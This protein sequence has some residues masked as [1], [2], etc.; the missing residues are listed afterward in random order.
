MINFSENR[1]TNYFKHFNIQFIFPYLFIISLVFFSRFL[2]INDFG[3]YEDD[4]AFSGTAI[5]NN[6]TQNWIR[7][8][9]SFGSFWQGRPLHMTFLTFIPFIGAKLGG[10][11]ALYL[12]GF[13][14]L[15]LNACLWYS[16]LKKITKNKN[17]AIIASLLFVLYPADTTFGLLQ[18]LIGIQTALLFLLIAFHVYVSSSEKH[19]LNYFR[20]PISYVFATLSLLDYE[21]LFLIFLTAPLLNHPKSTKKEKLYHFLTL[22]IILA[23]YLFLRKLAGESR[24]S[25]ITGLQLIQKVVYQVFWGPLIAFY[26]FFK[27]PIEVISSPRVENIII[28]CIGLILFFI[29]L[30]YLFNKQFLQNDIP[31]DLNTFQEFWKLSGTGLLMTILGYSS[32]LLLSVHDINGRA[33]RVHFSAALGITLILACIWGIAFYITR[34][35]KFWHTLL[36]LLLSVYLSFLLTFS[37]SVQQYYKMSWQY[38]QAFWH[39]VFTLVPDIKEGT[40]ILVQAPSLVWGKQINPFDWSLPVVLESIYDFPDDWQFSPRTYRLNSDVVEPE[41]W[42]DKVISNRKFVLSGKNDGLFFYFPWEPERI[43]EP[44]D[45]V[46]LVEEQGQLVRK[47]KFQTTAGEIIY[48]KPKTNDQP[49]LDLPTT[50]IFEHLMPPPDC[51]YCGSVPRIYFQPQE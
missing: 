6:L 29:V 39:D 18:H 31:A 26:S 40:I 25:G 13:T 4:W 3:L 49:T 7:L 42:K 47:E 14:I 48:L 43:V 17:V 1:T 11:R 50:V 20:K 46:L 12:I 24:I 9:A 33:S 23:I 41:Q 22:T 30:R 8:R 35:H 27:R 16:L 34:V 21:S 37:I 5:S 51:D 28:F 19:K 2:F 10:I 38:Q 36:I 32:A 45:V 44:Q 15:S